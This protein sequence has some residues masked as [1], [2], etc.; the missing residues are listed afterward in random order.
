MTFFVIGFCLCFVGFALMVFN[1]EYGKDHF[2]TL[3]MFS[4]L[5]GII[6]LV[7]VSNR[8]GVE[9]QSKR[10]RPVGINNEVFYQAQEK[11]TVTVINDTLHI[12][13][14]YVR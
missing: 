8:F 5:F 7:A 13:L 2:F 4:M 6:F 10:T 1:R 9:Y 14:K 3:G 12:D 11:T